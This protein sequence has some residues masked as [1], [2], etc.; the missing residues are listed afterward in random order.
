LAIAG[1]PHTAIAA[2]YLLTR[3][4]IELERP[5]L[6]ANFAQAFGKIDYAR[7]G[8]KEMS[9]C[10]LEAM[11]AF[12]KAVEEKFGGVEQYLKLELGFSEGDIEKIKSNLA[13]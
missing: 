4:G 2:D 6:E 9:S 12:L 8:I 3:I 13:V 11:M 7:P 10:T 1:V 5:R